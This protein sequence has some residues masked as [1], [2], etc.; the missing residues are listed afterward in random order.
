VVF[1]VAYV[2]VFAV[3]GQHANSPK[4]SSFHPKVKR[5]VGVN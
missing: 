5:G 4:V 3:F 2:Q 1:V